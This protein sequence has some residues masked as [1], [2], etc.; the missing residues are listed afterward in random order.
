[1]SEETNTG[2]KE[3]QI[4]A[5]TSGGGRGGTW[6][7]TTSSSI[8]E[9]YGRGEGLDTLYAE[10]DFGTPC[11]HERY[12]KWFEDSHKQHNL[13][14]WFERC[15]IYDIA[16]ASLKRK[17]KK[18]LKNAS[19]ALLEQTISEMLEE[20]QV[21]KSNIGDFVIPT[22]NPFVFGLCGINGQID[23]LVPGPKEKEIENLYLQLSGLKKSAK[24]GR[25]HV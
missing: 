22:I 6:K 2:F 14:R 15:R 19:E 16:G 10:A 23:N 25:A 17:L 13:L 20:K 4:I 18:Q 3:P 24:I 7:T 5:I 21:K 11:A 8:A 12:E 1:M 9:F